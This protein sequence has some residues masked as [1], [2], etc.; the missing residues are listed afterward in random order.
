MPRPP[1]KTHL[2]WEENLSKPQR[3]SEYEGR[4]RQEEGGSIGTLW[5]IQLHHFPS[6]GNPVHHAFPKKTQQKGTQSEGEPDLT[7]GR[8]AH[9]TE[10]NPP[11]DPARTPPNLSK[12]YLKSE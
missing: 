4:E 9:A 8:R 6:P 1:H 3:K 5:K 7:G 2:E 11:P 10:N 12:A